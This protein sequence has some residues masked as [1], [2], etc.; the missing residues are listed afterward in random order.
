MSKI[1]VEVGKN[2]DQKALMRCIERL[3]N[4]FHKV[5]NV[6]DTLIPYKRRRVGDKRKTLKSKALDELHD[7]IISDFGYSMYSD[8]LVILSLRL[9]KQNI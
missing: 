7:D 5:E 2:Q 9:D 6:P 8:A 4:S 3:I 1:T